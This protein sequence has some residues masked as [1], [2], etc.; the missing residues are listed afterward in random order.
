M[1]DTAICNRRPDLIIVNRKSF[2]W[3][4]VDV[5]PSMQLCVE[6]PMRRKYRWACVFHFAFGCSSFPSQTHCNRIRLY[7]FYCA[8]IVWQVNRN[9]KH[10]MRDS[11]SV[12]CWH[13]LRLVDTWIVSQVIFTFPIDS[14]SYLVWFSFDCVWTNSVLKMFLF[15]GVLLTTIVAYILR[16]HYE[17]VHAFFLSM[18]IVGPP[19]YP[20]I[21]NGLLFLNN[22]SA[23]INFDL[24]VEL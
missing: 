5:V 6:R 18:K 19:A 7:F 10:W 20:I 22:S 17:I 15:L 12:I 2:G 14:E 24:N 9:W 13:S 8:S 16:F 21:G 23:G 1:S 4:M 3:T 11:V